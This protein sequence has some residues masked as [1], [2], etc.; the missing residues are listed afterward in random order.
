MNIATVKRRPTQLLLNRDWLDVPLVG[1]QDGVVI[2]GDFFEEL[3][4]QVFS[5]PRLSTN[6][7]NTICPDL[8]HGKLVV[9]SKAANAVMTRKYM[10]WDHQLENYEAMSITED[11]YV[12]YL[13][14]AYKMTGNNP[15]K[16]GAYKSRHA[17]QAALAT[18]E[19]RG[20]FVPLDDLAR[21]ARTSRLQAYRRGL[22]QDPE[23]V[24]WFHQ[25]TPKMLD[26]ETA[27]YR[28]ARLPQLCVYDEMIRNLRMRIP[29]GG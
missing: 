4:S 29:K 10:I 26:V 19:I 1:T 12:F 21:L 28:E 15:D 18:A 3:S 14:W 25:V 2:V 24:W 5:L 16:V 8:Q 9:E 11:A 27:E 6:G 22:N 7:C 17:L 20:W 23:S 13:F